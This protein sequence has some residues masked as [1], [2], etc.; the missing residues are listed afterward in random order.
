MSAMLSAK[1]LTHHHRS[2]M[3]PQNPRPIYTWVPGFEPGPHLT[4]SKRIVKAKENSAVVRSRPSPT[5][6]ESRTWLNGKWLKL[7]HGLKCFQIIQSHRVS[8]NRY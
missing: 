7:R 3:M 8:I 5:S 4:T 1:F 2:G 6:F